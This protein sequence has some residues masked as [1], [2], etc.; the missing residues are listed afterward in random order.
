MAKSETKAAK[1]INM[2]KARN[3]Q[4]MK[5]AKAAWY[6]VM[7]GG[8]VIVRVVGIDVAIVVSRGGD[9]NA[10]II[11]WRNLSISINNSESISIK[12]GV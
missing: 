9:A 11:A 2:A 7:A 12:R 4:R 3:Q 10:L 5:A 1:N 8:V 6:L